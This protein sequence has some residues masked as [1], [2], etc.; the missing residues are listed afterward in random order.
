MSRILYYSKYCEHSKKLLLHMNTNNLH[1]DTH[2]I[3]IDKRLQDPN[4]NK[5]YIVLENGQQIVLPE[6]IQNVPA[7]M[8][9]N[10][11][12]KV[13]YGD[14]IYSFLRPVVEKKIE[15]GTNFNMEP[16]CFSFASDSSGLG[17][18]S[19]QYSFLDQSSEEMGRKGQGG[20]RQMY[21]YM[22][23]N[24]QQWSGTIET[25]TDDFQYSKGNQ[26]VSG[27]SEMTIEQL[28]KQ[29]DAEFASALPSGPGYGPPQGQGI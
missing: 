26:E 10:N 22:G 8:L 13:L 17:V 1:S 18:V 23:M 21:N 7:L 6:N 28:Q 16:S 9:L 3:C 24:E 4:T 19:D 11:N 2:F 29:R 27:G 15:Q 12:Y 25:P 20:T 14:D 5:I